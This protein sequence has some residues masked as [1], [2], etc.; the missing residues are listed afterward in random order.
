MA[1]SE[2]KDD[3]YAILE[4][5]Q[6]ATHE[7]IKKNFRRLAIAVHPDKN[8]SSSDATASFQRVNPSHSEVE[9]RYQ[10]QLLTHTKSY[11]ALMTP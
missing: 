7:T 6:T 11:R 9:H 10:R 5:P 1:P 3:Y 2:I 4:I 8:P